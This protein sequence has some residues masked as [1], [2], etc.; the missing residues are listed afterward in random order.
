MIEQASPT[1]AMQ[2]SHC[3]AAIRPRRRSLLLLPPLPELCKALAQA[4]QELLN[5]L[6]AGAQSSRHCQVVTG[7][8]ITV[9]T[10]AAEGQAAHL[11]GG[12]GRQTG[13]SSAPALQ[14]PRTG[15]AHS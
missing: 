11:W 9:R 12:R 6:L 14:M 3:A 4:A 1:I 10:I 15:A 2:P 8:G 13:S 5:I 7:V